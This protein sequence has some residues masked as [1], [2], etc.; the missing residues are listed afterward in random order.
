MKTGIELIA[1]ERQRQIEKEGW[2]STHDAEHAGG[3]MIGASMCYAAN[4]LNKIHGEEM[5]RAQIRSYDENGG[6][7][8]DA[9]PWSKDW[10]KREKH[11]AKRSLII[12]GAL[13]AAELDRI[14]KGGA[15]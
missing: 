10:D 12:A 3:D 4:A 8:M 2:D 7:W 14:S 6:E 13:I 11:D 15:V 9:W 1:E 5:A